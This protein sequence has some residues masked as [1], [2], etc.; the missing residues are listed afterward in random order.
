VAAGLEA[1]PN[2]GDNAYRVDKSKYDRNYWYR[3]EFATPALAAGEHLWLHFEGINRKGDI[4][5]N[6]SHLGLLDG[7][8]QRG[9]FDITH[10]LRRDG[11]NVLAVLNHVVT[12]PVPNLASPTYIASD[13]WDWMPP[14]PGLL[15]GITDD[16]YL[17]VTRQA[18]I[19]DPWM[20]VRLEAD[21]TRALLTLQTEVENHTS[22]PQLLQLKGV[23]RPGDLAFS[24]EVKLNP[25]ER[26][27]V[28]F[29]PHDTPALTLDSPALWWPNGYGD[30][31][32][33]T[34]ALTLEA[35]GK[36][37]DTRTVTFGIRQYDYEQVD[38]VFRLKVNGVPVF[39]R[40]GNW[41]M[42][43]WLLRCRGEEY[44]LKIRL[45]RDMHY[46]MIRNWIG[47]T[48]DEEF[49]QAC[50]RYGIMVW[51]DFWLNSHPNLPTDLEAFNRNAIEKIV[52][53]RNHACIAVWCGDN[54]GVPQPPLDDWLRGD[55][56]RWDGGDRLYQSISNS[57]GLSG[58]GPWLTMDA[59]WYY[60]PYPML[61]GYKGKPSYGFRT[62][63]G[64]VV[65]TTFE[66]FKRFM[67]QE[68]WWPEN[69]LWNRHFFGK[70]AANA[71]P[72]RF[73]KML[74]Q[75]YGEP[76]GIEDFCRK[77]QLMNLE[78]N[79]AMYEGWAHH[80]W[81]DA[82]GIMTWMSQSA[83]PSFVWQTYDYYYDPTGAYW[84][85][86]KACEP[87][88]VQWS[89]ADNSVKV[90]N[91]TRADLSHATV[92][93]AVYNLDGKPV[94]AC[95]QQATLDAAANSAT[96]AFTLR[97]DAPALTDVHFIR[98]RL[99][100]AAG[101]LLSENLYWHSSRQEVDYRALNTLPKSKLRVRSSLQ[102][103]PDGQTKTLRTTV[104]NV[105]TS[106]AF[107]IHL[108]PYRRSDG[109][110]ILPLFMEENYFTLMPGETKTLHLS[111]DAS[112]LPDNRYEMRAAAYN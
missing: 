41:G 102:T 44:D 85:V 7:F 36:P 31:P 3:T 105:G 16:V 87:L 25:G 1:D 64:T 74:A 88:H 104:K 99:T 54:E 69:E 78:S 32:L 6:G 79:R 45:H 38:D 89:C 20:R 77:A 48:T 108:Q 9:R 68:A 46:N 59:A 2:Y 84:G 66:S 101:K 30:Q 23:I 83:Y 65:F 71:G 112:L 58:S 18:S 11:A 52:R 91:T 21:N 82:T 22:A 26:R 12:R 13:G 57:Q 34:C 37:S 81:N 109:E 73:T 24:R 33:Y 90:I 80:L 39:V 76:T 50:D 53:L 110:R 47:S 17:T 19:V 4:Y 42:S 86:K 43:E 72:D 93:A 95:A 40:G 62:E 98:L 103:S 67:P 8:M 10:L 28:A 92:S 61:Y 15:S 75:Y 27:T 96:P 49:Y 51:D 29:N 100:D 70:S 106:V 14:V 60:R 111:F 94:A 97:L 35:D 5:L 63:I 56:K 55:V 107:A